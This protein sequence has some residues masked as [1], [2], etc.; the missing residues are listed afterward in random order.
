[1]VCVVITVPPLD[2]QPALGMGIVPAC[3]ALDTAVTHVVRDPTSHA[4]I[5]ADGIDPPRIRLGFFGVFRR[6]VGI[7]FFGD[8]RGG[9]GFIRH[10]AG[11]VRRGIDQS[12]VGERAGGTG[13]HAFTAGH[14]GRPAQRQT[15]V[16]G[17]PRIAALA[18]SADDVVHLHVVASTDAPVAQDARVQVHRDDGRG[19][20]GRRRLV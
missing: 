15:V 10:G 7:G 17:D 16:E 19:K 12:L 9:I 1:M 4:A 5:G 20:V 3:D 13:G 14:A 18:R 8:V 2:T 6:S 11:P